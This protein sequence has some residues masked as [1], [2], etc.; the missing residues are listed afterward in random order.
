MNGCIPGSKYTM[1]D[2]GWSNGAIFKQFL[3]EHFIPL[4]PQRQK[5]EHALLLYDGHSSHI[6]LPLIDLAKRHN[7]ILFVLPP[8]TSH[9]LQPLD[10]GTF[11][12]VK[13]HYANEC[14]REMRN[15]PGEVITRYDVCRLI[16]KSFL[17]AVTPRNLV[18]SFRATGV[19][20]LNPSAVDQNHFKPSKNLA[21]RTSQT[22]RLQ[23]GQE[24][25]DNYLSS[26]LPTPREKNSEKK[27]GISPSRRCNHG[28]QHNS[29]T[30]KGV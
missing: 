29:K 26:K 17:K 6:S 30:E 3:E 2:S 20:P 24:K 9:A 5:D 11:R 8:H 23:D 28:K 10:V 14:Q 7:I 15:R 13:C 19:F 4:L 25:F 21:R 27:D 12:P 1:S 22:G 18:N 16:C